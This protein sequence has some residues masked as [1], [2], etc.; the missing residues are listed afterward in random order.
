MHVKGLELPGYDPRGM[1]G[2]ALTYALSGRGWCHLRSNTL[3]TALMG[4]PIPLD[5][6]SYENKAQ[7][8]QE[9]QLRPVIY[10]G[11]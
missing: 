6:Y 3:R 1:K 4:L 10:I 5:R 2:E 8:V 9:L 11:Y 7:M